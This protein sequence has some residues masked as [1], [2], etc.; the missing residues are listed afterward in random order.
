MKQGKKIIKH[1]F[2]IPPLPLHEL[3]KYSEHYNNNTLSTRISKTLKEQFEKQCFKKGKS[4]S[5]LLRE[6]LIAYL[7]DKG[8]QE[9]AHNHIAK[10]EIDK[11][12]ERIEDLEKTIVKN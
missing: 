10:Y 7:K 5:T 11:L 4:S 9:K 1:E 2:D 6:I 3:K 8:F 12:K